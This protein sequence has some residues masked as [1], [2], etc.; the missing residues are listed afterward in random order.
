M[1]RVSGGVKKGELRTKVG[2]GGAECCF[3][4]GG[5]RTDT[6]TGHPSIHP[7]IIIHPLN[8]FP[9]QG[10]W[11]GATDKHTFQAVP[12]SRKARWRLFQ[13]HLLLLC[14]VWVVSHQLNF[15]GIIKSCCSSGSQVDLAL[16]REPQLPGWRDGRR[17]SSEAIRES[18]LCTWSWA[19]V[20]G[21]RLKQPSSSAVS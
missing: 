14:S 10:C 2:T 20:H 11:D 12:S 17:I 3:E 18:S 13:R 19:V 7:S 9:L 21:Y 4:K 5:V 15:S 6:D 1:Q 8:A 16:L